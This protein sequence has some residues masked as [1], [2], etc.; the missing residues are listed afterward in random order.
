MP[1]LR[2]VTSLFCPFLTHIYLVPHTKR[3]SQ[4]ASQYHIADHQLTWLSDRLK[5]WGHTKGIPSVYSFFLSSIMLANKA[6][7]KTA[8][9]EGNIE[10]TLCLFALFCLYKHQKE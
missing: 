7:T 1:P 6:Y 2:I 9:R 8:R 10:Q 4:P 3:K 5:N